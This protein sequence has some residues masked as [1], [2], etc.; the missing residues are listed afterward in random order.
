MSAVRRGIFGPGAARRA[1]WLKPVSEEQQSLGRKGPP[2]FGPI[3]PVISA[4]PLI[5]F[6]IPDRHD[7]Q[8]FS[9]SL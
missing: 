9:D 5:P 6:P 2:P 3:S 8:D 7:G 1:S 4:K